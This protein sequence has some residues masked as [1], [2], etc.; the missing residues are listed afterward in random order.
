MSPHF[1]GF[2][3]GSMGKESTCNAGDAGDAGLI[4]QLRRSLE[5]GM[6]THTSILAWRIPWTEE[7]G[8]LQSIGSQSLKQLSMQTLLISRPFF[9]FC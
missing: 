8:E 4:P 2:P 6:T 5:E 9:F 7:P 3:I 1:W